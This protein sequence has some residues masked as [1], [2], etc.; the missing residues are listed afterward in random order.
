M[1]RQKPCKLCN[2]TGRVFVLEVLSSMFIEGCG[3][4]EL[5]EKRKLSHPHWGQVMD[6]NSNSI[7]FKEWWWW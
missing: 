4:P 3:T 1:W 5:L 6:A 7:I 2:V